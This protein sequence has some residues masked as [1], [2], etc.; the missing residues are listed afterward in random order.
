MALFEDYPSC[1]NVSDAAAAF[2]TTDQKIRELLRSGQLR[3]FKLGSQWRIPRTA[4]L[5]FVKNGEIN[6]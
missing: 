6:D 1:G 4:L 3:G 2:K 5:E